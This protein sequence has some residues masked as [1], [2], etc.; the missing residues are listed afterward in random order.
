MLATPSGWVAGNGH[1]LSVILWAEFSNTQ[2]LSEISALV[3][4]YHY[5]LGAG[6]R[7]PL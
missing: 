4:T 5:A 6:G 2:K 1:W 7:L 3:Q